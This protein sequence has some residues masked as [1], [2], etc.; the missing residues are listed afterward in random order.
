MRRRGSRCPRASPGDG[1][2]YTPAVSDG[3][4]IT[5][6][7]GHA[8]VGLDA[9][10]GTVRWQADVP[11]VARSWPRWRTASSTQ[12]ATVDPRLRS[13]SPRAKELWRVPIKGVPYGMAVNL[14]LVLVGIEFGILYAI[15]GDGRG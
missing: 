9:A 8:V 6:G 14:G 15:G 13:T 10:T 5:D 12:P 7:E 11:G 3:L 2:A 4:A 1:P